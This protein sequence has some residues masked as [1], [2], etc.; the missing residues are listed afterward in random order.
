MATGTVSEQDTDIQ[1]E[2]LRYWDLGWSLIPIQPG[3]KRPPKRVQWTPYQAQRA[4]RGT[5]ESWFVGGRHYPAVIFGA[6]SG[7]L[8]CRDF[9]EAGVYERWAVE[10]PDIADVL[11][12]VQTH[13]GWHVYFVLDGGTA[14]LRRRLGKSTTGNGDIKV[15]G[16]ELRFD[17]GSYC[18]LPPA[19]H[20]EGTRYAWHRDPFSGIPRL[21]PIETGLAR[22]SAVHD[23][24]SVKDRE[25]RE[26]DRVSVIR[27]VPPTTPD[28]PLNT[29]S[30]DD[31]VNS[32]DTEH[33]NTFPVSSVFN[34][35]NPEIQQR[36]KRNLPSAPSRRNRQMFELLRDLQTLD[37]VHGTSWANVRHWVIPTLKDW[38]RQA[39][40]LVT[41]SLEQTISEAAAGWQRVRVPKDR[42]ILN[43]CLERAKLAELPAWAEEKV[44]DE[45]VGLLVKLCRE[46]QHEVGA[47]QPFFLSCRDAGELLGV[48]HNTAWHWL[49]YLCEVEILSLTSPGTAGTRGRASEYRFHDLP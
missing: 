31:T 38:Y 45:R 23:K 8:A 34:V 28:P 42:S 36:I 29:E 4:D 44:Y 25:S 47:D 1:N 48:P 24:L 37:G 30:T 32:A 11:P 3:T 49:K 17:V 19:V 16:G 21:D 7:G 41:D 13:R 20:P 2:A 10:F 26:D 14:E 27:C 22:V 9:D 6:A 39:G 40:D 18:L 15:E 33:T 5:V 35:K 12:I 46:L 43:L